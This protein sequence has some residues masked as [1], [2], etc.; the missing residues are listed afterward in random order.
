MDTDQ[1]LPHSHLL[2][3]FTHNV[4]PRAPLPSGVCR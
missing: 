3:A 4:R 2:D 1:K